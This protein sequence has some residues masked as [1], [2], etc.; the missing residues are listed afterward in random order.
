MK[1]GFPDTIPNVS[2]ERKTVKDMIMTLHSRCIKI[3]CFLDIDMAFVIVTDF[4]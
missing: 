2:G 4:F 1:G 3:I